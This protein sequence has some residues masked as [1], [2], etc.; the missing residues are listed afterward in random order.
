MGGAGGESPAQLSNPA[1]SGPDADPDHDG[2]NNYAEFTAGTDPLDA[3]SAL[4]L[5]V[6]PNSTNSPAL[7]W[8]AVSNKS[9]TLQSTSGVVT[10]AWQRYSDVPARTTN[11]AMVVPVNPTNDARFFRLVTPQLP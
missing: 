10:G 9:Y 2:F 3:G 8:L 5:D 7:S 6:S 11:A 4:R 1:I